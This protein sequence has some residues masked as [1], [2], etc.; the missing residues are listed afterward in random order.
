MEALHADTLEEL[1]FQLIGFPGACDVL[2]EYQEDG[3]KLLPPAQALMLLLENAIDH[4]GHSARD[5]YEALFNY[6][7]SL[8]LHKDAFQITFEKLREAVAALAHGETPSY[9]ISHEILSVSPVFSEPFDDV[10]WKVDFK[11]DWIAKCV[12]EQLG[13]VEDITMRQQVDFLRGIPRAAGVTGQ[14]L[15]Q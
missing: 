8:N 4:F 9:S 1:H 12:V 3:E 5:V 11:S 15:G 14:F 13:A 6:K 7:T 2:Q 10:R